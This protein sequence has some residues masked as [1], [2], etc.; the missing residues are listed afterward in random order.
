MMTRAELNTVE[1]NLWKM[2]RALQQASQSHLT[3]A[4]MNALYWD[5]SGILR[6]EFEHLAEAAL[7]D[8]RRNG[9]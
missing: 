8:I 2:Y 5:A 9:T 3:Q 1:S 4:A 6:R 7:E